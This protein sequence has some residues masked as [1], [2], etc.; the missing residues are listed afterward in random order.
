MLTITILI[1][2]KRIIIIIIIIINHKVMFLALKIITIIYYFFKSEKRFLVYRHELTLDG[3]RFE[4][5]TFEFPTS[6]Y[7]TR[8]NELGY[9]TTCVFPCYLLP[10]CLFRLF[11]VVFF[12]W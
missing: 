3:T 1:I 2:N 5:G 12:W 10:I 9:P 7:L 6:N 8:S 11:F 4:P